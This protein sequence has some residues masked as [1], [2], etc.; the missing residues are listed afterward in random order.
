MC[1]GPHRVSSSL[2]YVHAPWWTPIRLSRD[3]EYKQQYASTYAR[4][5]YYI[6]TP[7]V[8]VLTLIGVK[9]EDFFLIHRYRTCIVI[10]LKACEL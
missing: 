5:H 4:L 7:L 3:W 1:T 8:R 2:T 9:M 10:A 6:I